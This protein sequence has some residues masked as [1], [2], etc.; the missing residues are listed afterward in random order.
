MDKDNK[1]QPITRIVGEN[2]TVWYPRY[3]KNTKGEWELKDKSFRK[4][5]RRH[6]VLDIPGPK[7]DK[8]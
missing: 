1:Q 2:G 7:K 6:L 8:D 4:M 3:H 5:L